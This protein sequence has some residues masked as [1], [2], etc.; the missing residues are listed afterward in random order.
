MF[1]CI[2]YD[3]DIEVTCYLLQELFL[4]YKYTQQ[5]PTQTLQILEQ[6]YQISTTETVKPIL[7]L[8]YIP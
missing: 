1:I 8:L 7:Q 2:M 6:F 4:I 5:W 3:I